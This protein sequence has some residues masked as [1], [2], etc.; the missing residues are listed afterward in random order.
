[1]LI[2]RLKVNTGKT[3]AILFYPPRLTNVVASSGISVKINGHQI[4]IKKQ[5]ES[6]GVFLDCNLKM[7]RQVNNVAK[8]SYFHLRRITKVRNRLNKKITQTLVNTF[9][10]SRLDFCNSLLCSLPKKTTKKLQKVQNAAA[11]A[12]TLANRRE[13]VTPILRELHWLPIRYRSEYKVL[14][15]TY[16]I[17]NN[18]SS[19]SLSSLIH[20]YEPRRALRSANENYLSRPSIPKN[21]YGQRAMSN[22]APFLW[23]SIPSAVRKAASV[24][25]F[26][27]MLK[28]HF[29]I[30]H[31]GSS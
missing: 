15:L 23:N 2:N 6:L 1:M 19:E 25:Q 4:T 18:I 3:D 28:T 12:V 24:D 7:E 5:I 30:E 20:R 9:V 22:L 8:R 13:H 29:Y 16:R 11:K 27:T 21:K 10:S 14:L 31:F 26:K 17:L